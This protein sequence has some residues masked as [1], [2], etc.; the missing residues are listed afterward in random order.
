[1]NPA[2]DDFIGNH[3]WLGRQAVVFAGAEV[4]DGT[5]IGHRGVGTRSIPNNC[6]AVGVPTRVVRRNIAWERPHLAFVAPHY[7]PDASYVAKSEE[8][9]NPTR[10][11][12]EPAPV[13][14]YDRP[15]LVARVMRRFG[16]VK[17]E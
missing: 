5:V 1:M 7:K 10:E 15:G 4:G 11:S 2:K 16:Y 12:D 13:E 14:L 8:Y 9:W 3:V 6:V 17:M